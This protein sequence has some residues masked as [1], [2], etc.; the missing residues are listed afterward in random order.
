MICGGHGGFRDGVHGNGG[1]GDFIAK[2][3]GGHGFMAGGAME[4]G[5]WAL[6]FGVF[7]SSIFAGFDSS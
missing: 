1:G 6:R 2:T 4:A 5:S 3:H 7:V